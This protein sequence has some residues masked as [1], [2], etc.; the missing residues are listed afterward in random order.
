[1]ATAEKGKNPQGS[2]AAEPER[3]FPLWPLIGA[4]GAFLTQRLIT[5]WCSRF[6]HCRPE[7]NMWLYWLAIGL[8]L[9]ASIYHL[10]PR[11]NGRVVVTPFSLDVYGP[12]G[13][14]AFVAAASFFK[15]DGKTWIKDD[16]T[17]STMTLT[18]SLGAFAVIAWGYYLAAQKR[19]RDFQLLRDRLLVAIGI[20]A[21]LGYANFGHLHFE[22]FIH[23]WDTYHYY[24]GAKYFPEIGY[25][26]MYEC[27]ITADSEDL[28]ADKVAR[29]RDQRIVTN[30]RTNIMEKVGETILTR[31]EYCK[32]HF[33]PERWAEFKKDI[34]FF[35]VRVN[36]KRWEEIHHDHGYNASPVWTLFGNLITNTGTAT[37]DQVTFVD[38]FDPLYLA[39]MAAM[40]WWAFG[41]RVFA[42][43]MIMLGCNWA[44]RFFYWTGGALLRHDW[45]FYTVAVVCLLR[46]G[47]PFMAGVAM[48]YAALLRLFP[49]LLLIG[50]VLAAAEY[51]RLRL[52]ARGDVPDDT[53]PEPAED[54]PA[55]QFFWVRYA[56][57][58]EKEQGA[59]LRTL[60][61]VVGPPAL[62]ALWLMT[63]DAQL[64]RIFAALVAGAVAL[65]AALQVL[66]V[67]VARAFAKAP[68][69]VHPQFGRMVVGGILA[70]ALLGGMSLKF[71]GGLETW[72]R[73]AQNTSKHAAT[74]LTNSMGLKTVMSSLPWTSGQNLRDSKVLD[75][76]KPWKDMR[77]VVFDYAR[78]FFY[79]ICLAGVV[80]LYFAIRGSAPPLWATCAMGCGFICAPEVTNY[81]Y[82]FFVAIATLYELRREVGMWL[83]ALVATCIF[84][85]LTPI[86]GMS[87]WQDEQSVAMSISSIIAIGGIWWLFTPWGKKIIVE[88]EAPAQIFGDFAAAPSGGG[89]AGGGKKKKR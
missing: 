84:I 36:D 82:V 33:T 77:I 30:L 4:V 12:L 59:A 21:G 44:S 8:I 7:F 61:V 87:A 76:W 66:E 24:V 72:Q 41:P 50:P 89:G 27:A 65:V 15:I 39:L 74:P 3:K 34:A 58:S 49:G 35:R 2:K 51:A 48:A 62:A 13:V 46:K 68:R 80:L 38:L 5:D 18:L 25:D 85:M 79:L 31:P 88:P 57:L 56:A 28:P 22:N 23:T 64:G 71:F 11:K 73:F 43:A 10:A 53:K 17:A 40:V 55:K 42:L 19:A 69:W 54:D 67:L 37:I 16:N 6:G 47:R 29:M 83:T 45:L 70:T 32:Q 9:I 78:P 60:G 14:L 75:A 63:K 86:P 26:R 81:Y 20:S 52:K 1:M